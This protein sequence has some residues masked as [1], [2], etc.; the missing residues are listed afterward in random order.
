M[1]RRATI[2]AL[3]LISANIVTSFHLGTFR[4][5]LSRLPSTHALSSMSRAEL[6]DDDSFSDLRDVS[7]KRKLSG[8]FTENLVN[9]IF[10]YTRPKILLES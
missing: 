4:T 9:R 3:V 2:A 7:K 8:P 1:T 6:S 5:A 10:S